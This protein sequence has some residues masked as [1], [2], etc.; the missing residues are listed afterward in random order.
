MNKIFEDYGAKYAGDIPYSRLININAEI[1]PQTNSWVRSKHILVLSDCNAIDTTATLQVRILANMVKWQRE[2]IS[3]NEECMFWWALELELIRKI[4]DTCENFTVKLKANCVLRVGTSPYTSLD[5]P[6]GAY[7]NIISAAVSCCSSLLDS[8]DGEAILAKYADALIVAAIFRKRNPDHRF[9]GMDESKRDLDELFRFLPTNSLSKCLSFALDEL[10]GNMFEAFS[11]ETLS[12]HAVLA[13][14]NCSIG[15]T[16]GLGKYPCADT[17]ASDLSLE[18]LQDDYRHLE[19]VAVSV[20]QHA[21]RVVQENRDGEFDTVQELML[22]MEE[23][24]LGLTVFTCGDAKYWWLN[25]VYLADRVRHGDKNDYR[26]NDAL[27]CSIK[28]LHWWYDRSDRAIYTPVNRDKKEYIDAFIA[29]TLAAH[30]QAENSNDSSCV[31]LIE[32]HDMFDAKFDRFVI[33]ED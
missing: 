15:H 21:I 10:S 3:Q 22:S 17:M 25:A 5:I 28:V 6:N 33:F 7:A 16:V 31:Y 27:T 14:C 4:F 32:S 13:S 26:W 12:A 20:V 18:Y 8:H 24:V 29:T 11:D 9:T 23:K 1:M 30:K 2:S 19:S